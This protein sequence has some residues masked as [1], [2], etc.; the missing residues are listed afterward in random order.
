MLLLAIL[1]ELVRLG[2][3]RARNYIL[4]RVRRAVIR[5]DDA[6]FLGTAAASAAQPAGLLNGL[7]AVGGGSPGD[8]SL[9]EL[10]AVVSEGDPIAPVFIH[11]ARAG[12]FLAESGIQAFRDTGLLGGRI[13]GAPAVVSPVAAEKLILIDAAEIAISDEG[14][15]IAMSQQAAIEMS[16]NPTNNSATPT[17]TSL[18]SAFQANAG[19]L[20]VVRYLSWVTLTEDA[21]AFVELPIGGSPA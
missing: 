12:A 5:A 6:V 19:V 16:D 1:T 14:L 8:L 20:R 9:E 7:T 18:V 17:A 4:S 11:S 21:V 15:E 2:D 3:T 10:V 13:A